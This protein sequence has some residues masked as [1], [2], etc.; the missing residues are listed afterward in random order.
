MDKRTKIWISVFAAVIFVCAA[1]A[2]WVSLSGEGTVA[3]ITVDGKEYRRIDL[4]RVRESYDLVVE[5]EWGTN[6][7]HVS[8]GAI[9][10]TEADCPDRICVQRGAITTGGIPIICMPHRL[11]IEIEGGELYV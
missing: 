8:P 5:T 1:L 2:V 11:V 10:V 3:V 4:S 9:S 6:T 7:V